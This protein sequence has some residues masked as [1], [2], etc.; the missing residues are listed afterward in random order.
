MVLAASFGDATYFAP[1]N[2]SRKRLRVQ[3]RPTNQRT[4]QLFLRHQPLHI[5]RLNAAA[6]KN[7]QRRGRLGRKPPPHTLPQ[8]TYAT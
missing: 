2:G 6:V 7:P 1:Y 3:A 4:I 8:I 5:L